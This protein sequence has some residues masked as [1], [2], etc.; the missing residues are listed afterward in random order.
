MDRPACWGA[1][2]VQFL[3][4]AAVPGRLAGMLFG[5]FHSASIANPNPDPLIQINARG[6]RPLFAWL[7]R[8]P[9]QAARPRRVALI[10]PEARGQ[11]RSF[12]LTQIVQPAYASRFVPK[13][14]N[15]TVTTNWQRVSAHPGALLLADPLGRLSP[16]FRGRAFPIPLA[17]RP[18]SFGPATDV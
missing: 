7:A 4:F 9:T 13:G 11:V 17:R 15:P 5:S 1:E 2:Y 8:R 18:F 6:R 3:V 16:S 10:G 12:E 14:R